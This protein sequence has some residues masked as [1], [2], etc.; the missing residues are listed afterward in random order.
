MVHEE[1]KLTGPDLAQG[2][3]LDELAD[4]GM[5]VGYAG[6]EQILLVRR[7]KE[8]FA[9]GAQC[10]HYQGPLAEGLLVGNTVRCPWHHA[11]FDLRNGEAVRAPAF[12]P[13]AC[14]NVEQRDG[15][16]S[17]RSKRK[18]PKSK[19]CDDAN[20]EPGKIVIIGGGAA[21]FAAAEMLRRQGYQNNITMLSSDNTLPY[22]RP[23][24]SKDYLAGTISF[25]YVPLK[26]ESFY[27]K[28]HIET[29]LGRAVR[30]LDVRARQ[31]ILAGEAIPYDRLLLATGAEPVR[32]TF[33]GADQPHVRTLR[34]LSDCQAI[35]E[36]AKGARRVIVIGASFIGLEVAAALRTRNLEVHVVAPD[37]R[38]MER[39][40]GPEMGNFVRAL[41][42][43]HGVI[44]HLENKAV[45]IEGNT[46]HLETGDTLE[47]DLV[48]A[49]IGVRP[50]L[51]LAEKAGLALDRGVVVD[52]HL[53]T[54][55]PGIYA[56]GDIARWPD[57]HSGENIRVEHWVVAERQ[58]QTVALNMLGHPMPFTA[59]PF[60]WS[61]HYEV[62][63]NYVGHAESWD[64]IT[65][66][67]DIMSK[68]CLLRFKKKGRLAAVAS[69]F[70]DLENLQSELMME[71]G[72]AT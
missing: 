67:G 62:P 20:T 42:E 5:L 65:I 41:H 24:L 58:G 19:P 43:E 13:L 71:Q 9:V 16:I 61:Q 11:C 32:L 1:K 56:A 49:G 23:N 17:V 3:A 28:N 12:S 26:N 2:I 63:I 35:I 15:M 60:F 44:F 51:E 48:V 34:S 59:V 45:A 10:T 31:V 53:E 8:V 39:I 4:G 38:P 69:I 6:D 57:P 55:A 70:R 54:S 33:T 66:D 25:E 7:G 21:G 50:R 40:L 37:K 22:D 47:A 46:V 72:H 27:A 68:D 30:E 52:Q 14:W 36:R 29:R 18:S 64:E